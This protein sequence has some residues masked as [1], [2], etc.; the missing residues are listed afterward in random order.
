LGC[1]VDGGDHAAPPVR[2]VLA[3]GCVVLASSL[4]EIG[5]CFPEGRVVDELE[6]VASGVV[7]SMG[8]DE[9]SDEV[10]RLSFDSP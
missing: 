8:Q 5:F 2:S 3:E 10:F 9:G 6:G 1:E 4:A 7:F